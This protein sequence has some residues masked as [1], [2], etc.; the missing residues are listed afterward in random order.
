M[1]RLKSPAQKH[2]PRFFAALFKALARFRAKTLRRSARALAFFFRQAMH[3]QPT[4]L[5]KQSK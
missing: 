1:T 4:A 5:M 2:Y 3:L